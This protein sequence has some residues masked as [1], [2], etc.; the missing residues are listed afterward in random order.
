MQRLIIDLF[1]AILQ[2]SQKNHKTSA[3]P[4]QIRTSPTPQ[5][6]WQLG[7][8]DSLIHLL[9]GDACAVL[10]LK[11][12]PQNDFHDLHVGRVNILKPG[13]MMIHVDRIGFER[14][15]LGMFRGLFVWVKIKI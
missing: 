3:A 13:R 7:G 12:P 11:I 2:K 9:G 5:I 1:V 15:G 4:E 6:S 10:L 14:N 8:E